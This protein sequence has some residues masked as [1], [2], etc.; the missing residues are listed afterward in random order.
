VVLL[1]GDVNGDGRIDILDI[2]FVGARFGGHDP[3]ADI[4]D[5]GMVDI[6]DL[7]LTAGNFGQRAP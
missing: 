2:A 7:V 6:L 5:D 4:N 3:G 1:G